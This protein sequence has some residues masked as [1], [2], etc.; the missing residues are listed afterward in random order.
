GGARDVFHHHIEAI[1][2]ALQPVECGD[3]GM[4]QPRECDGLGTEPLRARLVPCEGG[5]ELLDRHIAIQPVVAPAPVRAH[6]ALA[7]PLLDAVL[8]EEQL[9]WCDHEAT[10]TGRVSREMEAPWHSGTARMMTV[11]LSGAPRSRAIAIKA[12][13][14][15]C[16]GCSPT[17][18]RISG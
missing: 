12:S 7:Q 9:T 17:V 2:V 8:A 3:P 6:P 13:H 10:A 16:G 15:A 14:P 5:A 4:R 18:A 1:G 11:T